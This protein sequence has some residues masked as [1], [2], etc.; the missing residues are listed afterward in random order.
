MSEPAT[1][2]EMIDAG[3]TY[4]DREKAPDPRRTGPRFAVEIDRGYQA[5]VILGEGTTP[6]EAFDHAKTTWLHQPT[7]RAP[8]YEE[9]ETT[10]Q[11]WQHIDVLRK[12]LRIMSVA[13]LTRGET[14]DRSKLARAE[15]DTFTEFTPKLRTCTYGSDEYKGYL[16]EMKVALD[17]HYGH[18]RHHPEHFA[19]GL[20]GMNLV[21]LLE[22]FCDWWAS[23]RRHADGDIRRSIDINR[24]RFGMPDELVDIFLNT[25]RDYEPAVQ[26]AV[27]T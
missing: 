15:V 23:S 21:D 25:V 13:L 2:A 26:E 17:H 24:D 8:S 12:F 16:A 14:H 19:R 6:A 11:T 1:D 9:L 10:A 3:V 27:K 20:R 22:M 18:N 7:P 5:P 4:R